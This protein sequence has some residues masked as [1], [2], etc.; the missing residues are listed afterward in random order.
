[1]YFIIIKL[2]QTEN[3]SGGLRRCG[4][5][6]LLGF[7]LTTIYSLISS[8]IKKFEDKRETIKHFKN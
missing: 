8:R 1:M 3:I 4:I 7:S 2:K 6:G 5:A